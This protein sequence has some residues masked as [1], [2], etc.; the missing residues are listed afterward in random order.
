M[1]TKQM[2]QIKNMRNVNWTSPVCKASFTL[3]NLPQGTEMR[4]CL[5]KSGQNGLWIEGKSVKC[6]PWTDNQGRTHEYSE[7]NSFRKMDKKLLDQLVEFI[8][9]LYNEKG[10]YDALNKANTATA[11]TTPAAT[12][13]VPA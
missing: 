7:V 2:F 6:T 4:D 1:E 11:K 12:E 3:V 10:D 8:G 13:A 9:N 5:L